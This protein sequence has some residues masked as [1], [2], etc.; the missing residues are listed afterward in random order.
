MNDERNSRV[1]SVRLRIARAMS[2]ARRN[3]IPETQ[4]TAA[5]IVALLLASTRVAPVDIFCR[6]WRSSPH[7]ATSGARCMQVSTFFERLGWR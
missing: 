5:S 7:F 6:K 3:L 1:Y 2:H 4:E